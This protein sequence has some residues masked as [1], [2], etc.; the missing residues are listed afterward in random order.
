MNQTKL[1]PR[2]I[3]FFF[4]QGGYFSN[5]CH[6][7]VMK[8]VRNWKDEYFTVSEKWEYV[9]A[10]LKTLMG[11]VSQM[12]IIKSTKEIIILRPVLGTE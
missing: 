3:F 7:T 1:F 8:S 10:F 2:D 6:N 12:K 11:T 4:L 5:I 9:C